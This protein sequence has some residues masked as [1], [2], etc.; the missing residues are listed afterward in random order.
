[1]LLFKKVANFKKKLLQNYKKLKCKILRILLKQVIIYQCFFD[2]HDCAFNA[3]FFISKNILFPGQPDVLEETGLDDFFIVQINYGLLR[4]LLVVIKLPEGNR[5]GLS[6]MSNI[7]LQSYSIQ[8][9][10]YEG[11]VNSCLNLVSFMSCLPF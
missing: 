7:L 4:L 11:L 5:C 1:M 3:I 8:S 2:L 6:R 10:E 9:C